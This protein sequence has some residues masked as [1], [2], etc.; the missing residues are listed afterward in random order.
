M[1]RLEYITL[2]FLIVCPKHCGECEYEDGW[3]ICK[4]CHAG[5]GFSEVSR[6]CLSESINFCC[7]KTPSS[8]R[9]VFV[10]L[11]SDPFHEKL[12]PYV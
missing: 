9:F 6:A 7:L 2:C 10:P 3:N 11:I 4:V 12:N 8:I 1:N 5:Y